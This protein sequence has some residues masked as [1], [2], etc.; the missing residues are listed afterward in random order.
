MT[1]RLKNPLEWQRE[2]GRR[3]QARRLHLNLS[4]AQA[5]ALAGVTRKTVTAVELGHGGTLLTLIGLLQAL[6]LEGEL[7]RLVPTAEINPVDMLALAGKA[8]RRA[9]GLR[10]RREPA[11]PDMLREAPAKWTWGTPAR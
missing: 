1:E 2:I 4:Q 7:Q 10:K 9:T 3:L 11:A 5:A 6:D 8:R